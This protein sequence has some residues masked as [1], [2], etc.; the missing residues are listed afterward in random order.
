VC[1]CVCVQELQRLYDLEHPPAGADGSM[2]EGSMD[3]DEGSVGEEEASLA[4]K[5]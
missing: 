1:V 2:G 3:D 4:S 5:A